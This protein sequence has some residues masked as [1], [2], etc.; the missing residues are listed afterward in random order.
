MSVW[1]KLKQELDEWELLGRNATLWWRDDDAT[2]PSSMLDRLTALS[3]DYAIPVVLA[4]VPAEIKTSLFGRLSAFD[5]CTVVQH[6]FRHTNYAAGG[7]KKAEFG[8][9]RGHDNMLAELTEGA[10][11]MQAFERAY[12]AL[13]PPWNRIDSGLFAGLA[14]IGFRAVSTFGPRQSAC[15]TPGLRQV[16]THV[17]PVA[18]RK[19]R[20]FAGDEATLAQLTGHLAARR[21]GTVD[22]DEPTGLLTH[23]LVCDDAGWDFIEAL[24]EKTRNHRAARWLN[25]KEAFSK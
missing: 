8:P 17:D 5:N 1:N 15:P 25:A 12:P 24:F 11:N 4:V 7:D 21:N 19:G 20:S 18:W 14:D 16:N 23:H 2:Q 13:A 3:E 10:K 6:G 9:H 22:A